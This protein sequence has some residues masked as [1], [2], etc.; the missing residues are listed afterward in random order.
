MAVKKELFGKL[1]DGRDSYIFTLTN[2]N[3]MTVKVCDFAAAIVSIVVPDKN[4][5]FDDVVLSYDNPEYYTHKEGYLGAVV[6]R[7]AN[8]IEN[9]VFTLN[10][11]EVGRVD[12]LCGASVPPKLVSALNV[13]KNGWPE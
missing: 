10:G 11:K 12:L 3:G 8:R 7:V 9:S 13:L 6:G 4:G 5:T 2:K 1:S